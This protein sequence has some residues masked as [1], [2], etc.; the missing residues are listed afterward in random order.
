[1]KNVSVIYYSSTG[2]VEAMAEKIAKGAESHG[3]IVKISRVQDAKVNDVLDADIVAFGSPSMDGN[4]IESDEM[5]PFITEFKLIPVEKKKC[6]LFGSYG[7]DK[8]E[9]MDKWVKTMIDYDFDV[10]DKFII[11]EAPAKQ[12]LDKCFEYGK[13][14]LTY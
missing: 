8:G 13:R 12:D 3:A 11:H 7:W 1:M 10:I 5:Q 2:H 9:F 6:F 4:T 14:M